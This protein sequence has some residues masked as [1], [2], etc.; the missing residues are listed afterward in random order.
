MLFCNIF[1]LFAILLQ[2]A[3]SNANFYYIDQLTSVDPAIADGS[4]DLPFSN[5]STAIIKNPD[6]LDFD[7][8]LVKTDSGYE[9]P[10]DIP[11]NTQIKIESSMYCIFLIFFF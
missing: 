6:V 8:I 11:D 4:S 1:L 7:L 10:N 2:F 3:F 5:I 9:F